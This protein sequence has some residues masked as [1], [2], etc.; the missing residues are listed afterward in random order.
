MNAIYFDDHFVD[1]N[2][3]WAQSFVE[4]FQDTYHCDPLDYAFEGYDVAWYFLTALKEFGPH[5]QEC[6]PY[7]HPA[8]LHSR[9][10]FTKKRAEDGLENRFW[11]I[12]Q[13]DNPSVELKPVFIY[14]E[15]D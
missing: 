8:L 11:N 15:E 13:Y 10:Y 14:S 1:Y 4:K 12:Y 9:Y 6:L 3:D 5:A 7:Y 2:N